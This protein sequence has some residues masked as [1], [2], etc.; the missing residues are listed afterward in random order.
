MPPRSTQSWSYVLFPSLLLWCLFLPHDSN[1]GLSEL[2]DFTWG[3]MGKDPPIPHPLSVSPHTPFEAKPN[4]NSG[5]EGVWRRTA[6]SNVWTIFNALS[7]FI[8]NSYNGL[9]RFLTINSSSKSSSPHL[10]C[11]IP[12]SFS[13]PSPLQLFLSICLADSSSPIGLCPQVASSGTTSWPPIHL[14]NSHHT[15]L[16]SFLLHLSSP[17]KW[18]MHMLT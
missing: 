8:S 14:V 11:H 1:L 3:C 10:S 9:Q 5:R 7:S 13:R 6:S 4:K 15:H 12:L 17:D 2:R 16:L 18:H